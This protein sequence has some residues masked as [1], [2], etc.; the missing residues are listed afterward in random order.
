[1]VGACSAKEAAD[2]TVYAPS[3]LR[4]RCLGTVVAA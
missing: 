2:R 1:V 4:I 3:A